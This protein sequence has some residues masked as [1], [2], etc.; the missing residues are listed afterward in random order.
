MSTPEYCP[1]T[2][3][4][5]NSALAHAVRKEV[6]G[7]MLTMTSRSGLWNR[8]SRESADCVGARYPNPYVEMEGFLDA[9][10]ELLIFAEF[11]EQDR[12]KVL[13]THCWPSDKDALRPIQE[14]LMALGKRRPLMLVDWRGQ[15]IGAPIRLEASSDVFGVVGLV[16]SPAESKQESDSILTGTVLPAPETE[17]PTLRN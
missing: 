13:Y 9:T 2:A 17:S 10:S 14:V 5:T 4:E 8:F 3:G 1:N 15:P 6:R 11:D 16:G 12:A 7:C